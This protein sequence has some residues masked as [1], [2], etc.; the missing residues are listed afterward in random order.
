MLRDIIKKGS[1]DRSVTL[2]ICDSTTAEPE[3]EILFNTTG[4]NLWYR[5]EGEAIVFINEASLPTPSLTDAHVDGG[6]LHIANGD[7]R[8]DLPDAAFADGANYLDFGGGVPGNLVFG[9][10]VRL[11]DV[12]VEDDVS[13]GL[14]S[15]I[16]LEGSESVSNTTIV[17][18]GSGETFTGSF[19]QN[20]SSH[21]MVSCQTDNPGTLYFDFSPDGT[22]VNSFPVN[23]FQVN[24][25]IHEFHVAVKGP[26]SFRVR[27]VNES[28][29]QS[30]L[31]LYTYFGSFTQGN[32][33]VNASISS[34]ADS[35][36]V[37]SISSETD[38]AFGRF[39]GISED[40]KF[41]HVRLID[42]ADCPVD[43]WAF[44]SDDVSSGAIKTFPTSAQNLFMSS[45]SASDTD[46]DV[47]VTYI[48]TDGKQNSITLNTNGTA[49]VD[50]GVNCFDVSR[51]IVTGANGAIGDLYFNTENNHTAGVPNNSDTVLAYIG[52]GFGQTELATFT[53]PSD[54]IMRI[55]DVK[56]SIGRASGSN[57][58]AV[59]HL[60][61]RE[62]G[63]TWVVKRAY[64]VTTGFPVV[65]NTAGLIIPGRSSVKMT[66]F[67]VSDSG[68]S[69]NA[70]WVYELVDNN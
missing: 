31:R 49:P 10:R 27:L 26:R 53:V 12:D 62:F 9:G 20:N 68:T 7:Y 48:D 14:S 56:A 40:Q 2:K 32:L 23:G 67:T 5:R 47:E 28:G 44:G 38:L 37:R 21:V 13:A 30:Y 33:P 19:E 36:V 50:S 3:T 46:V 39:Q 29:A 6:F 70:S 57:G 61:V 54:K 42:L 59:V 15:L 51:C 35:I 8:L 52:S 11:V 43:V 58:S 1:T 24:S 60:K 63:K 17:P 55:K 41:G 18:L 22:A 45:S 34:D 69:C 4:I 64:E 65:D 66:L 25:G 16:A